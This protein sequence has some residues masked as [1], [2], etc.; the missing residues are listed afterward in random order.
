MQITAAIT[1]SRQLQWRTCKQFYDGGCCVA[2]TLAELDWD[3]KMGILFQENESSEIMRQKRICCLT[4]IFR[5]KPNLDESNS[6][7]KVSKSD[8]A[9]PKY[10]SHINEI[11][12]RKLFYITRITCQS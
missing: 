1:E 3:N 12:S 8:K 2:V 11:L 4:K 10:H 6:P 9:Y 7:Y 5:T